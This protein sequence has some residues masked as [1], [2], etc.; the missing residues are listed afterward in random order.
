MIIDKNALQAKIPGWGA[1]LRPENRPGVPKEKPAPQGTGAHWKE[2]DQQRR[3][4]KIFKTIERRDFTPVFGNTCPPKLLSGKLRQFAY[5]L[6]EGKITRWVTLLMSDR[7]DMFETI[8]GDI[9]RGEAGN[10]LREMGLAVE[11]RE[12]RESGR[13]K[14]LGLVLTAGAVGFGA[15]LLLRPRGTSSVLKAI[16]RREKAA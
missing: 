13:A 2:P 16:G 15:Y 14:K 1:D 9:W 12:H 3:D 7:I 4:V 10:P 5:G 11:F 6:G 8:I